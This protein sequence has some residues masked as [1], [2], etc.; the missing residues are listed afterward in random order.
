MVLT[1]RTAVLLES[2]KRK[3]VAVDASG[4]G[5]ATTPVVVPSSS[6]TKSTATPVAATSA[7]P[8]AT[9]S[10]TTVSV[11]GAPSSNGTS[12]FGSLD[13]YEDCHPAARK[14]KRPRLSKW[15][16]PDP[17]VSS[18]NEAHIGIAEVPA[19]DND[20]FPMAFDIKQRHLSISTT[21]I[22]NM[23]TFFGDV[24]SEAMK[25]GV[26]N[27]PLVSLAPDESAG[28][29]LS[30]ASSGET[31]SPQLQQKNDP[32]AQKQ[33][34]WPMKPD[35]LS[36]F[37]ILLRSA[38]PQQQCSMLQPQHQHFENNDTLTNTDSISMTSDNATAESTILSQFVVDDSLVADEP[39]EA[40]KKT[41][42]TDWTSRYSNIPICGFRNRAEIEP[43]FVP[44]IDRPTQAR[45]MAV[46]STMSDT[47]LVHYQQALKIA[48]GLNKRS[49]WT[50]MARQ[51]VGGEGLLD[52]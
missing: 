1:R 26:D 34:Y 24:D 4:S 14:T 44:S 16:A 18:S 6:M 20:R 52:D 46:L 47:S 30:S 42:P 8:R 39:T 43:N 36:T 31:Q 27:I 48:A 7:S 5:T 28:R 32:L 45:F 35:S 40:G 25:G 41:K 3:R 9:R 29:L 17:V 12:L 21:S 22:L 13:S 49:L 15:H 2:N 10:S 33:Q 23:D 51:M 50:G 19:S 11:L 38:Q 37:S